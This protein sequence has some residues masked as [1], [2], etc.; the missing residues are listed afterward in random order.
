M[1]AALQQ[2]AALVRP[3]LSDLEALPERVFA[4][5]GLKPINRDQAVALLIARGVPVT[6]DI[7]LTLLNAFPA[8]ASRWRK[9]VEYWGGEPAGA[10][11]DMAEFVHFVVEDLYEKAELD[12]VGSVFQIMERLLAEGGQETSDLIGLGFFETLQCFA[13]WRP[14][15]NK[16]FERF[17]GPR[18]KRVWLE[19]QSAWA[20]KTSLAE[21]IRAERKNE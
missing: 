4:D 12:D 1:P 13:S 7:I 17:L 21:V 20:D 5:L 2:L 19:L 14:Y 15:G 16:V 3:S 11:I 9:P 8:F 6:N 18:S 10:Y